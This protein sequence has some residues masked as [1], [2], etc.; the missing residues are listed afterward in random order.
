MTKFPKATWAFLMLKD[1]TLSTHTCT[2][3]G[4]GR[5]RKAQKAE[6]D[7]EAGFELIG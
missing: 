7:V 1:P 3:V 2:Q 6:G 5:L 4:I